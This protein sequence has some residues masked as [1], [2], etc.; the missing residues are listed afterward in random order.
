MGNKDCKINIGC[1]L[2]VSWGP[3][4]ASLLPPVPVPILPTTNS[5]PY[6]HPTSKPYHS[7]SKRFPPLI[8]IPPRPTSASTPTHNDFFRS[9]SPHPRSHSYSQRTLSLTLILPLASLLLTNSSPIFI[10]RL[11]PQLT[12]NSSRPPHPTSVPTPTHNDVFLSS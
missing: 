10:P 1:T 5:S 9:S 8:L 6:L 3:A 12:T 7:N 11:V 2:W 4:G